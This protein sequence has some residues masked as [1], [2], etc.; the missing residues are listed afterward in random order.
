MVDA[1]VAMGRK[2]MQ[3]VVTIVKPETILAWQRRLEW[4]KWDY[5]SRPQRKSGRPRTPG[6]IESIV[7][8]LAR[9]NTWG[10]L[11]I[12]GEL[13]KLDIPLSKG[14]IADILRRNSLP[15]SPERQGLTWRE[16]LSR[17]AEVMLCADLFT[18]E[19]W[20]FCGL[21]TAYVL[22]VM[23][24][25]T[26][27][28]LL[29][30]ATFCP[31]SRWMSQMVR[32]LLMECEE[33]GV[34]PR[35]MLHD[36]DSIFIHSFDDTLKGG[37][38]DVVR[39]PFRAPNANAHAER[40]VLSA[41]RE[42]LDHLILFGLANLRRTVTVYRD[43][44]NAL[45]PHQGLGQRIPVKVNLALTASSDKPLHSSRRASEVICT[46]FLGGLLKSY[47]RQAA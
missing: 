44:Y 36:R 46:P 39:T 1:A 12:Q 34:Q 19:I 43:Y 13:L 21:K 32:N 42:C 7:C 24:L 35:S 8:R 30:E 38:M 25:Q 41:K 20:T 9:E 31:H 18:K 11:R 23:H 16:F 10:Y 3:Q 5:S 17:H 26:R 6:N 33:A 2:L 15:P 22:F 14:C 45:R 37:G 29:A 27:Q 28:I 40:W 47:S 4:Q